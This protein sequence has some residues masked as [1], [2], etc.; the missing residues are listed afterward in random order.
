M[1]SDDSHAVR[2]YLRWV[3]A[4]ERTYCHSC[5]SDHYSF[6][7]D[8]PD[9]GAQL[10]TP[11]TSFRTIATVKYLG[12]LAILLTL[13]LGPPLAIVYMALSGMPLIETRTVEVTSY[14]GLLPSV[15][16][17]LLIWVSVLV[18]LGASVTGAIPR[19]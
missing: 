12:A 8:C 16:P 15:A 13:V 10:G 14:G 1:P 4:G 3:T 6:R 17:I 5:A 9:C 7:D 19:L 18:L 2:R 11:P